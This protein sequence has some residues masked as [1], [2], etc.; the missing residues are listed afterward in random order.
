[1]FGDQLLGL[2]GVEIFEI[3]L[4]RRAG[5]LPV[6]DRVDHR[7]RR[8]GEDREGRDDDLEFA[9]AQLVDGQEGLILP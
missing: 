5:P 7:H 3:G 9:L 1:M 8:L 6:D 4:G 2:G